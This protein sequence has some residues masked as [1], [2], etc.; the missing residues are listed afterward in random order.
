MK[1][2]MKNSNMP[3]VG[4]FIE[5]TQALDVTFC[6]C[7]TTMGVMG[8]EASDLIEGCDVATRPSH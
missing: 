4:E 7:S 8:V 5:M 1:K 6:A 2:W 3:T